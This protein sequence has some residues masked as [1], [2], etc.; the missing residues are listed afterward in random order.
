M[1]AAIYR[2][3]GPAVDTI[4][5]ADWDDGALQ[6]GDARVQIEAAPVHFGD[7]LYVEGRLATSPPPPAVAGSEGLGRIVELGAAVAGL[8]LGQRVFLPRK[9][10]AFAQRLRFEAARLVPAPED[11]DPLQLA[12]VPVNALTSYLLMTRVVPLQR[13]D[14]VLQ[15]AAN[16]SCGRFNIGIAR[17]L[18][19]RTVNVVRREALVADLLSC[20]A[21]VALLDGEDL[22]ARVADATGGAPIRFAIDAVAGDATARLAR[23]LAVDGVVAVYGLMSMQPCR[24]PSDLLFLNNLRLQGYFLPHYERGIPRDEWLAIM[25]QLGRWVAD[26]ELQA[27]IAA[28]YALPQVREAF[29]HELESGAGR[30][31]KVILLPN[32]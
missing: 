14:W 18:G 12:L 30:D 23:C 11:G 16:S 13:G 25:A 24:V 22:P 9:A 2:R 17:R 31:G 5:L 15:N 32:A 19:L 29:R 8:R 21:D 3:H 27:K 26:G 28:T 7:L 6:P 10:G 20:G 1:L 4:E